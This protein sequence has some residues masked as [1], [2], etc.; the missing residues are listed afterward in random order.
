MDLRR[1]HD[2]GLL[3]HI[4]HK[5]GLRVPMAAGRVRGSLG[6]AEAAVQSRSGLSPTDQDTVF[7]LYLSSCLS[8]TV[9]LMASL[10]GDSRPRG[11]RVQQRAG[12]ICK[13]QSGERQAFLFLGHPGCEAASHNKSIYWVQV[14]LLS[15]QNKDIYSGCHPWKKLLFR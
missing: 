8:L 9:E 6:P 5:L 15:Y 3:M 12:H 4:Y 13:G 7:R 10:T 11:Q 14:P 2:H 1:G